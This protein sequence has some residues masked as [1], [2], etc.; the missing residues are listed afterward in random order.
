MPITL[1]NMSFTP[2]T[3]LS[4]PPP[5]PPPKPISVCLHSYSEIAVKC[6]KGDRFLCDE[7][8]LCICPDSNDKSCKAGGCLNAKAC[9]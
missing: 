6:G 8:K 5:S 4:P 7:K 2:C 3:P 9:R 1:S